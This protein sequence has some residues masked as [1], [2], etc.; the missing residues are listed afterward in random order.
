MPHAWH[1]SRRWADDREHSPGK[2]PQP[3]LRTEKEISASRLQPFSILL[4]APRP[5]FWRRGQVFS[6][7]N[8]GSNIALIDQGGTCIHEGWDGSKAVLRPILVQRRR[9]VMIEVVEH[10]HADKGHGV[11]FLCDRGRD[12]TFLNPVQ[13]LLVSI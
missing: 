8:K 11:G 7:L 9:L 13:R 2:L 3:G 5:S 6:C 1:D 4:N 12:H 10:L